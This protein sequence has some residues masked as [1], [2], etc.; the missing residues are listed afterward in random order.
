MNKKYIDFVPSSK[1]SSNTQRRAS[2]QRR[3]VNRAKE[4]QVVMTMPDTTYV[5]RSGIFRAAEIRG[6]VTGGDS[7]RQSKTKNDMVGIQ[8]DDE[9]IQ[10]QKWRGR[11]EKKAKTDEATAKKVAVKANEDNF[12][13]KGSPRLGVVEDYNPKFVNKNVPKRPLHN[14]SV[15]YAT[16]TNASRASIDGKSQDELIKAKSQKVKKSL[17]GRK[18]KA[19][20]KTVVTKAAKIEAG[21]GVSTNLSKGNISNIE[22]LK[23]TATKSAA[24][25]PFINREKVVKRP[26][27]KNVYQKSTLPV[28]EAPKGPVTIIS[29]P[30]KESKMGLLVTIILTI[31]LGAAAGTIAFLLLP[32]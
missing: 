4:E 1:K 30:E 2:T 32:K 18:K 26:L 3:I 16:I 31:I 23:V 24:N 12:S 7:G 9:M 6:R 17:F 28:K 22:A 21:A 19:D 5:S 20:K 10:G 27:S 13:I 25:S 11:D 14:E 8:N 29:T 15:S